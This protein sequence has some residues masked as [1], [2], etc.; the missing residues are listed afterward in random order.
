M[1]KP[2]SGVRVA[3]FSELAPGPFMTQCLVDMGAEVIKY[4]RPPHGDAAR[5]MQP[6]GFLALNQG[7]DSR[8]VNLKDPAE[9]AAVL[10]VVA[11][12]D[13]LVEGF[14]PGVMARLGLGYETLSALNPRLV[15]VSISGYG[16]TGPM[17]ARP[18]HDINYLAA[19]GVASLSGGYGQ[20]PKDAMGVPIGDF[21]S[22]LYA[23]S[24]ALAAL[25]QARETGQGQWLDVAISDCLTHWLNPRLGHFQQAG[26]DSLQAQRDNVFNKPGYGI[27]RT[28]DGEY[29]SIAALETHFWDGLVSAL[30]LDV[31]ALGLSGDKAVTSTEQMAERL[32]HVD[33]IQAGISAA[34]ARLEVQEVV[35]RLVKAD[36]PVAKVMAP[37]EMPYT[38][39]AIERGL[40]KQVDG[41][42][43]VRFPVKMNE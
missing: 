14:R 37:Y 16:Q 21:C 34:V 19:S 41:S 31:K 22:S 5:H 26:I 6:G 23:L 43:Y 24:S 10:E 15:Y 28:I 39:Q 17:A 32:A 8:F 13:I 30:E 33:A 11:R 18:G 4:E 42:N 9:R 36:V 3:D 29:V 38:E 27:Y 7:K 25:L 20:P 2:L 40:F 12:A 1:V 35:A